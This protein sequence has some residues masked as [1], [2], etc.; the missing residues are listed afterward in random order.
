MKPAALPSL[1]AS[2]RDWERLSRWERSELGRALR[3]LGWTYGEIMELIPVPKGTLAHWCRDTRLSDDQIAA[4]RQRR[5]PGVRTGIPV[6]T[7]RRRRAEVK[8]IRTDAR[9]LAESRLGDA[10]FVAGVV[11]YWSE[12]AK[13]MN[14]LSMSHSEPAAL[15][16]FLAWVDCYLVP[17]PTGAIRINLYADNDLAEAERWWLQQLAW[18]HCRVNKA[19]VKPDGTGHRRNHLRYGVCAVTIDRSADAFHRTMAFVDVIRERLDR[20]PD[21]ARPGSLAQL[22]AA[23]DS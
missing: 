3:R 4:I 11:L 17:R 16:L 18:P 13:T 20:H 14:R 1:L 9:A 15:S 12:G 19:Y 7:Q 6:D 21:Y 23:T 5:P 22:E 10:F 8:R 2:A